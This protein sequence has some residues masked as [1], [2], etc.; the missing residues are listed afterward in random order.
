M[1]AKPS[2]PGVKSSATVP[3][4][5]GVREDQLVGIATELFA[6]KGYDGTSLRD[7]ADAAGITKAA[8]YYWF[9]EKEALFVRVVENRMGSLIRQV[10]LAIEQAADPIAKI[11]AFLHA[12]AEQM[13]ANRSA[14]VT[15]SINFWSNFDAA[16]REILLAQRDRFEQLLRQCVADAVA[17]GLLRPADPALVT[18]LLLS[19]LNQLPRWHK[20]GG[21]LSAAQ[22]VEAYLDMLL[23]GLQPKT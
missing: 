18:R 11:R 5:P 4:E 10:S 20:P 22:V 6:S 9:P 15:S 17:Q 16:Q 12:S 7:I 23:T 13:D 19:G 8:L 14:W 3:L 2:P 21:R 1:P